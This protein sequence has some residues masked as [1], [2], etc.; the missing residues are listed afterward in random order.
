L[1]PQQN[2]RNVY[3]GTS[4][5]SLSRELAPGSSPGLSGLVRYAEYFNAV[6]VNSTFYRR[7]R[8]ATIE[9]WRETT[10]SGF[11]FAV[12]LPKSI[13]H[14]ARLVGVA[15]EVREFCKLC[16]GFGEKLG[17]LLVQL[18]PSLDFD[19]GVAAAFLELLVRA[20]QAGVVLEPRHPSWFEEAA[21]RLLVDYGVA[22]AAAD[23]AC[24]P[25]AA[26]PLHTR[27]THYFRWHGSPRTYF[28]AYQPEALAH[29]AN[30]MLRARISGGG[31]ALVYCFLDNTALGAASVNAL[32]LKAQL[33]MAR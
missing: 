2:I 26:A 12:K 6:E 18:P 5:W 7:P 15:E 27:D 17:P 32:T 23:P 13:T 25:A 29:L 24:C 16:E 14:E 21:E 20:T 30:A 3:V 10:P 19:A 8:A 28:S 9:R 11:R 33:V 4:G 22:R 31:R 1:P